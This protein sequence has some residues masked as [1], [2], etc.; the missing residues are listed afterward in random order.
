MF[1]IG[2]ILVLLSGIAEAIMDKIQFHFDKS[3]FVNYNQDFW[4]PTLSWKNKWRSDLK[5]EKFLWSSSLFVFVTDGWHLS[6]FFRNLFL[7]VGI[8]IVCYYSDNII[9]SCIICRICFGISFT[10]FF[11]VIFKRSHQH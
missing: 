7:F 4:N 2:L 10:L 8:P 9:L 1:I 3:I 6:K 5:T 11:N